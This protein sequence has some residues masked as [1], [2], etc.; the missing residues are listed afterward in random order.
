MAVD[1]D[2][3]MVN[4]EEMFFCTPELLCFLFKSKIPY[5]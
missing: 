1:I 2:S 5:F 4:A 3:H